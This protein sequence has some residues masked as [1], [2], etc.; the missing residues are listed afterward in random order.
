MLAFVTVGSTK[1]DSLVASILT[2]QVLLSFQRRGYTDLI[3]QC[4]NSNFE[5]AES[6]KNGETASMSRWGV[7]IQVWK[8]KNSLEEE[9]EKAD[10]II[11]HA[12]MPMILISGNLGVIETLND[13]FGNHTRSSAKGQAD[14][15]CPKPDTYG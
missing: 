6:V 8:F 1:F 9:F 7:K 10:F 14:D 2:E 12:G 13:R 4:G 15:C 11:S 3:I 5:L